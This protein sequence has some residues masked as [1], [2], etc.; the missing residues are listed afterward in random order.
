MEMRRGGRCQVPRGLLSATLALRCFVGPVAPRAR[1][2]PRA[3]PWHVAVHHGTTA[4]RR[5]S[6]LLP[7]QK[8]KPEP[9]VFHVFHV[10]LHK[11]HLLWKAL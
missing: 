8:P 4:W 2:A 7:W 9:G 6:S 3:V 10:L 5:V 1:P 11:L